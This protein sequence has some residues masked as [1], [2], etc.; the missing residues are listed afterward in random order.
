M[1][2]LKE[3]ATGMEDMMSRNGRSS[4]THTYIYYIYIHT[5]TNTH[6]ETDRHIRGSRRIYL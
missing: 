1:L 4:F 2:C 5:H 3:E 6:T